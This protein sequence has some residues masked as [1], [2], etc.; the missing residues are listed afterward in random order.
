MSW[1]RIL[2]IDEPGKPLR[3]RIDDLF[4]QQRETWP[5]LRNGE[6]ALELLQRKTLKDRGDSVIVQVNPARRRST[7]ANTDAKAIAA[8]AC[9]LCP[10]NMPPEE[11]GA[12]I[13]LR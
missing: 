13:V 8:R 5:M 1:E 2:Q 7:T 9:F 4:T 12:A 6:A 3:E 10:E 11:R